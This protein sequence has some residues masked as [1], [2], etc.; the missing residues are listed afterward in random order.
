MNLSQRINILGVGISPVSL[1]ETI[2]QIDDWIENDD[3]QY[4]NLCTVHTIMECRK[5]PD[6]RRIVNQSGLSVPDGMPLVWLCKFFG[7][8]RVSRVYGPDLMEALCSH[9]VFRGYSH[10]FY[11]GSSGVAEELSSGMR[12][13]FPELKIAG[14]Y[15]PPFRESGQM[16]EPSILGWI[17]CMEPQIIWVG[18][19]TPKQD[20]WI[21]QHRPFLQ[22]PVLIA[23][24][25]AFDFHT[26]RIPKAPLWMQR[27]GLE[28]FFRLIQEPRRLAF[29]Y[30]VYNPLFIVH[31]FLQLF[32]L[33]SYPLK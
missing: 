23:V 24:G 17:N 25:A 1:R 29:R 31:L 12:R 27:S 22:A 33:R 21:A 2:R 8:K 15:S 30:L 10:F 7:A 6:L 3:R 26:N 28:W 18:L 14:N 9:S 32:R 16:E 4:I 5:D 11:G 20:V 19:G 13:Y